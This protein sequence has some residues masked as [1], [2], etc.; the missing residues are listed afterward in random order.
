[1]RPRD[2]RKPGRRLTQTL[3]TNIRNYRRAKSLSQEEL[4]GLCG[5]H[6]TYVGS[7]EREERNVTLSTLEVFAKAL[8][9][10]VPQLLSPKRESD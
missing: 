8:G 5:L 2:L 3:A 7:V 9:V 6:R 1:M 10:T 4:A